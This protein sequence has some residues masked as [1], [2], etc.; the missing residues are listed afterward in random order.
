[1]NLCKDNF[2]EPLEAPEENYEPKSKRSKGTITE[3]WD[4]IG[5]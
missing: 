4:D 2:L 5:L 1:M 3:T